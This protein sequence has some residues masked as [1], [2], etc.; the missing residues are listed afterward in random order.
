MARRLVVAAFALALPLLIA[1]AQDK[2][3]K[4]KKTSGD[5]KSK[6]TATRDQ[7]LKG[8]AVEEAEAIA[9]Q[10][11][12]TAISLLTSL[13]DD[14]RSFKEPALRARVQA[15]AADA[16]WTTERERARDLF[17]RAWEAADAGD[18][19][20]AR[21]AAEEAQR[22]M[23]QSG[24]L[25]RRFRRDMRSEVLQIVARRDRQLAN[26]FLKKI[27]DDADK[28]AKEA[29]QDADLARL[30]DQWKAPQSQAKRIALARAL[31]QEGDVERAMAFAGPVLDRVNQE[32]INFLSALRQKNAQTADA[33]FATLLTRAARD[34]QSD[35][36]TVAG[37]SSYAFTPFLYVTF[38]KDGGS[39]ANQE[40]PPT[41]APALAPELR[42]AF[43]QTAMSIFMRPPVP[44][45]QDT[46]TAGRSGK[47]MVIKR[48]L[49][50]FEQYAPQMAT[51][52][53]VAMNAMA[54]PND[55]EQGQGNRAIDRG[56]AD[57]EDTGDPLKRMQDRLDRAKT[58][59]ERDAIY[60]DIAAAIA[61]KGDAKAEDLAGK[62]EDTDF[63]KQTLAYVDFELL[64]V[65]YRKND[66]TE[67]L[68]LLKNGE[69][70]RIQRTW[71]FT[72][73]AR[74]TTDPARAM[75]LLQ[76]AAAEARRM[77]ASDPDRARGL[78]AVATGFTKL[79]LARTWEIL[80]EAVKSANGAEAFT[81]DDGQLSAVLRSKNMAVATAV[82]S[83]DFN[84]GDV[85]GSLAA[86]DFYRSVELAKNFAA[87]TPRANA[88]IA[89]AHAILEPKQKSAAQ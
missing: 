51:E 88:T 82:G 21:R 75:D 13:A 78:I 31:L 20:M 71:G 72:Q 30:S 5:Q 54:T 33:A 7:A 56:I 17:H 65:A 66:T 32:S 12:T 80:T 63:R 6:P 52:L 27:E 86:E 73:A 79:D 42:T 36:N 62:I 81:G 89:V 23:R 10:R 11:R 9:A 37:L 8:A 25:V 2:P 3:A 41:P 76:D 48:L 74:L 64:G 46:T 28:H 58:S 4:D 39:F 85:F 53:R 77:E 1:Q 67:I 61:N 16:L 29:A 60:A 26:E 34:P 55:V 14:A 84:V 59:A 49:P 35:A 68:R 70:T 45:E 40:A 57:D 69:L 18:A 38:S 19:E 87:E 50:L 83:S 43:F 24:T 44:P 22:Q 47:Y 15:R